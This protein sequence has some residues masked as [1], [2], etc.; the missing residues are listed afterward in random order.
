MRRRRLALPSSPGSWPGPAGRDAGARGCPRGSSEFG[1]R[2]EKAVLRSR[3]FGVRGRRGAAG[4]VAGGVR[5][6]LSRTAAPLPRTSSYLAEALGTLALYC[7]TLSA[8]F[9]VWV[10]F[11]LWPFF[12]FLAPLSSPPP[13]PR[14]NPLIVISEVRAGR[15]EGWK[16]NGGFLDGFP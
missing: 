15:A 16:F 9:G 14:L 11:G 8:G 6:S 4:P 2:Q 7:K 10:G 3:C 1:L 5:E 12:F 13:P